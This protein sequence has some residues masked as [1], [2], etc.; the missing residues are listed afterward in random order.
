MK[1]LTCITC[2]TGCRITID[3]ANGDFIFT[4]NKCPKGA[5]FA[6]AEM[7]FPVRSLTTTVR[8]IFPDMPVIPVRTKGEVPKEKIPAI[9]RELSRITIGKRVGIGETVA[10][11]ILETGCDIIATRNM[12]GNI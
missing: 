12:E 8:T 9:M 5:V 3:S 7:T 1:Q 10:V 6:K 2:P 11:N 4:G